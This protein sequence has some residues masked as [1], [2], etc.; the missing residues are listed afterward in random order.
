MDK[1][2]TFRVGVSWRYS[3]GGV[4]SPETF[5]SRDE[6]QFAAE[7]AVVN[8]RKARRAEERRAKEELEPTD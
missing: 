3:I 1:V 6:A 4:T 8:A 5:E 7:Q 2:H